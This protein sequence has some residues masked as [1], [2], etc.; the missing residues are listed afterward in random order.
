MTRLLPQLIYIT[1]WLQRVLA[2]TFSDYEYNRST[3]N[4][5]EIVRRYESKD[6]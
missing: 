4:T 2:K 3:D 6:H 1:P 5:L